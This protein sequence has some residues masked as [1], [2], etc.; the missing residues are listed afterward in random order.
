MAKRLNCGLNGSSLDRWARLL[1][2]PPIVQ[3]AV[4]QGRI[5]HRQAQVILKS[6][7]RCVAGSCLRILESGMVAR[8]VVEKYDLQDRQDPKAIGAVVVGAWNDF[9]SIA[10][11]AKCSF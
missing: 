3:E 10:A 2:L 1:V 9:A 5:T 4:V 6:A 11:T 7:P 8:D